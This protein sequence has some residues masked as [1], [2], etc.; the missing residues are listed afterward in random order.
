[1][2]ARGVYMERTVLLGIAGALCLATLCV[3]PLFLMP[4]IFSHEEQ[5][6][7]FD[8][9]HARRVVAEQAPLLDEVRALAA[10]PDG[11]ARQARFSAIAQ[12]LGA[13][14]VKV[15][16]AGDAPSPYICFHASLGA[17]ESY[18]QVLQWVAP[19]GEAR[20]RDGTLGLG[21]EH[22]EIAGGWYWAL[23]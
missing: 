1:M 22:R 23:H 9:E 19:A 4:L 16:E 17:P 21:E 8:V 18:Y 15:T 7:P 12:Q 3:A 2:Q 11:P 10:Q 14:W 20:L 6:T 13:L 5:G